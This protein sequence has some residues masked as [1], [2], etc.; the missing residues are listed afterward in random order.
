MYFTL[1]VILVIL[2]IFK[3]TK[4]NLKNGLVVLGYV[5]IS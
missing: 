5:Y 3:I 1:N 4:Q 2:T